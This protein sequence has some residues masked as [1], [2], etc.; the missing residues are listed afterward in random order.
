MTQKRTKWTHF[1]S[2]GI[3]QYPAVPDDVQQIF[4]ILEMIGVCWKNDSYTKLPEIP[5]R[6]I[7]IMRTQGVEIQFDGLKDGRIYTVRVPDGKFRQNEYWGLLDQIKVLFKFPSVHWK[8]GVP[9][10][11]NKQEDILILNC[12]YLYE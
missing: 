12:I 8:Q 1:I 9:A 10:D 5:D 6:V 7:Q 4:K 2:F 3:R 11:P